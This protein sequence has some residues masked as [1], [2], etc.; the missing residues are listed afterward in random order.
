MLHRYELGQLPLDEQEALERH[1]LDCDE[2]FES[3][4]EFHAAA[5]HIRFSTKVR[6]AIGEMAEGSEEIQTAPVK[7][8]KLKALLI[9]TTLVAILAFII[10]ILKPWHIEFQ[11][12]REAV[13][14]ENSL[15]VISF[16]NLADPDDPD[17]LGE[18]AASLMIADLTDSR[19]IQV[20]SS[21]RIFDIMQRLNLRDRT[22]IDRENATRIAEEANAK[23]LLTGKIIQ[24]SPGIIIVYEM[25]E[26][27][28]GSVVSSKRI[29]GETGETIFSMIDRITV[30]IRG[31]MSLPAIAQQEPDKL[32]ADIT[33]HS[34][35]AYRHYLE[36]VES[37]SKFYTS[38]AIV[39]F[40]RALEY[41]STFA[42]VYY[43]LSRLIDVRFIDQ[44]IEYLENTTRLGQYY[45]QG[46]QAFISGDV[47]LYIDKL[48]TITEEFPDEK[49]AFHELGTVLYGQS[50]FEES[51]VNFLSAIKIDPMYK[52][53]I[54][55]LAYTYD[56][57]GDFENAILTI[58]KY[59]DMVPGEPNPYDSRGD[60]FAH[61]GQLI[62]AIESY[63]K[64]LEIKPDY[65]ESL[66]K[67]GHLFLY[68]RKFDR[69]GQCYN[70][71]LPTADS[72]F[73]IRRV[74][75]VLLPYYR[76][77]FTQALTAVD[78]LIEEQTS[79][80][81]IAGVTYS[82]RIKAFIYYQQG[83]L[84]SAISTLTESIETY[85]QAYPAGTADDRYLLVHF[86]AES[87]NFERAGEIVEEL[88]HDLS[89]SDKE[90]FRYWYA[91][92]ALAMA[93]DRIEDAVTALEKA[94]EL[95][96]GSSSRFPVGYMLGKA[97]LELGRFEPAVNI[98]EEITGNY[99]ESVRLCLGTWNVKAHYY[100]GLAYEN[101]R[102][103]EKSAEQY[104]IFLEFWED[105][106][107]GLESVEDARRRLARLQNNL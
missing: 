52:E 33:T 96:V 76:G 48:K 18:I 89:D 22:M 58:N 90:E 103:Y 16:E 57:L 80:E 21:Q 79:R 24:A 54:N 97:Y 42:M 5:E 87:G 62:K 23:W 39:S 41:D 43:H 8:G 29:M 27:V 9:P 32:V 82:L 102:W 106:D 47:T 12:T 95:S 88:R 74:Y 20:I 69:A 19:Y 50:R 6:E 77:K 49:R 75:P 98:L 93:K 25:S 2:C 83:N 104:T 31:D 55:S 37:L 73:I 92:G 36:G 13:A 66:R 35:E 61:N 85:H 86:L 64:A 71:I 91:V 70:Q 34:A 45:I 94:E 1:L 44:A 63:S 72:G 28:D 81:E 46:Q 101:S 99:E 53:A 65:Y 14:S 26:M 107:P 10:L 78:E 100:L 60:L 56:K 4:S 51:K 67:L 17:R 15:A 38:E 84:T 40:T 105:S 30:E 59:I 68:Q 11:P 7:T 3:F